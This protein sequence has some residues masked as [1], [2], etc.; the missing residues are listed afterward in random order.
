MLGVVIAFFKYVMHKFTSV[1]CKRLVKYFSILNKLFV[2]SD[3]CA[4]LITC[5]G[6]C[7]S[8]VSLRHLRDLLLYLSS[9]RKKVA[10]A[11]ST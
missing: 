9:D 8:S 5:G 6:N 10:S 7:L 1:Q 2:D 4:I 11:I 3:L